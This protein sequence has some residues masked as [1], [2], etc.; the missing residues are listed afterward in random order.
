MAERL[1]CVVVG[2]G[3]VGLAI[4]RALARAGREV[5]VLEAESRI[6]MHASSRNSEVI[7]AGIYYAESSLKAQLCVQ[8][9]DMLYR[10][11][12]QHNVPHKRIG[13]L[14]V[15]SNG[16]EID[17]LQ[18]I[19][20]QARRNGVDDLRLLDTV[21]VKALEPAISSHGALLSPSTGIIDSHELMTS[22]QA[23]IEGHRGAVVLNSRVSNLDVADGGLRFE[24]GG[25]TFVCETLVNSGGLWAQDLVSHFAAT[26]ARNLAKGHY[27]A[28][29]G[30]SPFTC[31]PAPD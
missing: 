18:A 13:K 1:D 12:E 23:E 28:L 14:I 6:G 15:A 17:K 7:H 26:P 11:C 29:Q 22:L 24:S 19:E 9:K 20:Q 3:V 8:G 31:L 30:K 5:I 21:E 16:D 25:E 4:A 27:F 10:Y 2:A